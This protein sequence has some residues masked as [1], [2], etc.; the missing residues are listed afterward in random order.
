M[1]PVAAAAATGVRVRTGRAD[2]LGS[3]PEDLGGVGT[4]EF[5]GRLRDDGP[6]Q[7]TR[8]RVADKQDRPR[9]T[10]TARGRAGPGDA[11]AAVYCLPDAQLQDVAGLER[12]LLLIPHATI[13][14][15]GRRAC[16]AG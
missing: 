11:P 6:D 7:L 12:P 16:P 5:G 2:P 3:R 10:F 15:P 14:P 8:Q 4:R 9:P 13:V 1:L